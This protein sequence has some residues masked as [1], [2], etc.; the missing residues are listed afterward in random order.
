MVQIYVYN[1]WYC[2]SQ[3]A[4]NVIYVDNFEWSFHII[5]IEKAFSD[6]SKNSTFYE[7]VFN[8]AGCL[9]Y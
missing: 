8:S 5:C 3:K 6:E 2:F 1:F 9:R 4:Q 7:K